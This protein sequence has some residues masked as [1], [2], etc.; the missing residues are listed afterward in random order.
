[1]KLSSVPLAAVPP[2]GAP[3]PVTAGWLSTTPAKNHMERFVLWY[4]PVWIAVMIAVQLSG[5]FRHWSD[6]QH[7][8]LGVGLCLPIWLAPLIRPSAEERGKSLFARYSFLFNIWIFTFSFLQ[9][10]FGS[11]LF[12]GALGMQYHFNTTWVVNRT[13]VF[14]YFLTVVYFSSYYVVLSLLWR[15]F[16]RR[17]PRSPKVVVGAVLIVLGFA[18]AFAETAG[19]ANDT[20][21]DYFSYADKAFVLKYGSL[22]Y[23]TVFVCSLPS[24]FRVGEYNDPLPRA[25]RVIWD[26]CAATMLVLVAYEV[27]ARVLPLMH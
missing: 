6:W 11:A 12:F 27:Y 14:L 1:M 3:A 8:V 18:M 4:S 19:M 10:Y 25:R 15:A 24:I 21:K 2:V 17:W 22:A 20:L 23:G 9:V 7:M 26:A 13:P 16:L 5:A